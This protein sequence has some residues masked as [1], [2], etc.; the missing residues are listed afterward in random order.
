MRL[1]LLLSLIVFA[2]GC[3]NIARGLTAAG[4]TKTSEYHAPIA[5]YGNNGQVIGHTAARIE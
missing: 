1:L 2:S 5:V 3:A 4:N